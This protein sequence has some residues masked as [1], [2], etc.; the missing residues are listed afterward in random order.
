MTEVR[1]TEEALNELV[2]FFQLSFVEMT[3][4]SP[5]RFIS[6][7]FIPICWLGL[8]NRLR[9]LTGV[10]SVAQRY[11]MR[12]VAAWH[13]DGA[14]NASFH[15][16]LSLTD[17]LADVLTIIDVAS[18]CIAD[19][20]YR[21]ALLTIGRE[22]LEPN[23]ASWLFYSP[24]RFSVDPTHFNGE[25]V[26]FM[27]TRS[28]HAF[29]DS[30]C[31]DY[32]AFKRWFYSRLE[33]GPAVKPLLQQLESSHS[34]FMTPAK[35]N[36]ILVGIHLR[37]FDAS[38]DWAMVAPTYY[39]TGSDAVNAQGEDVRTSSSEALSQQ[40]KKANTFDREVFDLTTQ[41]LRN[42]VG[43]L[44]RIY[45]PEHVYVFVASNG[46]QAK[47]KLMEEFGEEN[48][49]V[50]IPSD[51]Q[52]SSRN[53]PFAVSLA[54]AELFLLSKCNIIF[55]SYASSFAR[56]AAA[57]RS[58]PVVD[59]LSL[60]DAPPLLFVTMA[61]DL[62]MCALPEFIRE[63]YRQSFQ[64]SALVKDRHCYRE[65]GDREMCSIRYFVCPCQENEIFRS[66]GALCP[67]RNHQSAMVNNSNSCKVVT[68]ESTGHTV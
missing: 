31:E 46:I 53:S 9:I 17:T 6:S 62:P 22:Y 40:L 44:R 4:H 48:V 8:A 38:F 35:P 59:I 47:A 51:S 27:F 43:N 37:L 55:H 36:A 7:I 67:V 61:P 57:F 3:Q 12:V 15:S 5:Y 54:V 24:T 2:R 1:S 13:R 63:Q 52:L 29:S 42:A 45:S 21:E 16:I 28:V 39:A 50:L 18:P 10:L 32:L 64:P 25:N 11:N 14:C 23:G 49:L 33:P 19:G 68:A 34:K 65:D 66:V 30:S 60:K 58:I 26:V 56:E 41:T 20:E